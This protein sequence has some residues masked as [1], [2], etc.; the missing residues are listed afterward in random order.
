MA[1]D[2]IHNL[3]LGHKVLIYR[4]LVVAIVM[5][6]IKWFC[7][8]PH[9]QCY[10]FLYY[11]S[12]ISKTYLALTFRYC[13]PLC[14]SCQCSY[15]NYTLPG[16]SAWQALRLHWEKVNLRPQGVWNFS[17]LVAGKE[18]QILAAKPVRTLKKNVKPILWIFVLPFELLIKFP[19][20]S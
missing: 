2:T 19:H 3:Y 1:W 13:R 4:H 5:C 20:C 15:E 11:F 8:K 6:F 17:F 7:S 16:L 10:S 18:H 12:K 9:W 14:F